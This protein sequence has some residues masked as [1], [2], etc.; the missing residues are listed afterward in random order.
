MMGMGIASPAQCIL[1]HGDLLVFIDGALWSNEFD[2]TD[3][4]KSR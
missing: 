4:G 3:Q 1:G 2:P